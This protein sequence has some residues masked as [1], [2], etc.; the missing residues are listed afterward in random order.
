MKKKIQPQQQALIPATLFTKHSTGD[1]ELRSRWWPCGLA[2]M[3]DFLS[4]RNCQF[5]TLTLAWFDFDDD[6]AENLTT[7]AFPDLTLT[8]FNMATLIKFRLRTWRGDP[9]MQ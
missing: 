3:V 1:F 5:W 9:T 6:G 2:Q 8:S 4:I 7:L